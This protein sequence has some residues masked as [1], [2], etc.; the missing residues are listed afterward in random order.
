MKIIK[1][2]A[3]EFAELSEKARENFRN[4]MYKEPF[5]YETGNLN[6]DGEIIIAYDYFAEWDLQ[7]QIEHC[8]ANEYLFD[9]YGNLVCHLQEID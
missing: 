5:E 8:D 2:K 7:N 3:Y 9:V 6:D 1:I 4:E